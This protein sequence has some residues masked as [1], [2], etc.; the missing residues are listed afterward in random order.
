MSEAWK[1]NLAVPFFT[2]RDNTYIWQQI[3]TEDE[4]DKNGKYIKRK[5]K[6][7]GSK[8]PMAWRTCNITSLCMILHYWGITDKTPNQMIEEVY[9]NTE[10]NWSTSVTGYKVLE[11]WKNLKKIAEYYI[12]L[13]GEESF[14]VNWSEENK[15]SMSL[16]QEQI[17]KGCP[18]MIST[19]LGA[20][21]KSN[22]DKDGNLINE[23]YKQTGH[24]VVV[25]GF[26][27]DGDVIL[28]DPY[29]IPVD[30]NSRIRQTGIAK[31]INGFYYLSEAAAV[32]D[33]IIINRKDFERIYAQNTSLF[34][35]I[36]GPLWQYPCEPMTEPDVE[37]CYPIKTNN[38]WHDGIHL[39]SAEGFRSI[40]SGRLM[41]ARNADVM[42]DNGEVH[43]S[44]SF[45]L[46]RYQLPVS[47][48]PFFYALYMHLKTVDLKSE[49]E[50]FMKNG[51]VS[52]PL[53][54]TWYEQIFNSLLPRYKIF[55]LS[56]PERIS[57]DAKNYNAIYEAEIKDGMFVVKI[58]EESPKKEKVLMDFGD[59]A[60]DAGILS[61][62]M[63]AYLLPVQKFQTVCD[64]ESYSDIAKLKFMVSTS[65]TDFKNSEGYYFFYCG[66]GS[67]RKLC[68]CKNEK[69]NKAETFASSNIYN[70][71]SYSYY[72]KKL[73]SLY[74]GE[75]VN[76]H[77]KMPKEKVEKPSMELSLS[78]SSSIWSEN[79]SCVNCFETLA[80]EI[81]SMKTTIQDSLIRFNLTAQKTGDSISKEFKNKINSYKADRKQ[82]IIYKL[83]QISRSLDSDVAEDTERSK[84]DKEWMIYFFQ[85]AERKLKT[86]VNFEKEG[87]YDVNGDYQAIRDAFKSVTSCLP[88]YS[89]YLIA[90]YEYLLLSLISISPERIKGGGEY[91]FYPDKAITIGWLFDLWGNAF[92][93]IINCYE[94]LVNRR[95]IDT[96]IEIPKGAKIG[97]G[98]V[99]PD[100]VSRNADCIHFEIFSKE[101]ILSS[102]F[103]VVEDTDEDNFYNPS[104][105]TER[106][107]SKLDFTEQK[108]EKYIKYAEDNIL[109]KNEIRNIY[110]HFAVFQN[111]VTRHKTEWAHKEY[112]QKDVE[113]MLRIKRTYYGK[114]VMEAVDYY[115]DY[116]EKYSWYD[117]KLF[118]DIEDDILYFCHPTILIYFLFSELTNK[119]ILKIQ[120]LSSKTA[121]GQY[122]IMSEIVNDSTLSTK[123]RGILA[124]ELR[125]KRNAMKLDELF[126][127]SDSEKYNFM[128]EDLR[129]FLN[130][131]ED[132]TME[133]SLSE[134][135]KG[136]GWKKMFLGGTLF[137]QHNIENGLNIK[138]VNDNDGREVVFKANGNMIMD[139]PDKGT[140]NYC[141]GNFFTTFPGGDHDKYDVQPF[142][143]LKKRGF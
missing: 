80:S 14:C 113:R 92:D 57:E 52:E 34:L 107:L 109:L 24:I 117:K 111:L 32:G 82:L 51:F 21:F 78:A 100:S 66:N 88:A 132:G 50:T 110:A 141:N 11:Y 19:G 48:N 137:H 29:G 104:V 17:A 69:I 25:R 2:Q 90:A 4:K 108:K 143:T 28:N 98:T 38:Y 120:S 139:Y 121:V 128:N 79:I 42:G 72:V 7:F 75:V 37:N 93:Y 31:N 131:K 73:Y 125:K 76:F 55:D 83:K 118:E 105:I 94:L 68:C 85:S 39:Q 20:N 63:K 27:N 116:Y 91:R 140:Y 86:K 122:E 18:V 58:N 53:R 74:K 41:A 40:G 60:N 123:E 54:G 12:S 6:P 112:S 138:Y 36:E 124:A 127:E 77:E 35:Y 8:Y 67:G 65:D 64:I 26:T 126:N 1:R 3:A 45:A 22:K 114:E 43:G 106:I 115:N 129:D 135:K 70:E 81:S 103:P 96:Y 15:L 61:R 5:G 44:G 56:L 30:N 95:Y 101:N 97:D 133:Y 136:N 102:E 142:R 49:L 89:A 99:I 46:V 13:A 9:S 87:K 71:A 84:T 59:G 130:L 16:L 10:W 33:N 23:G 47:E 119:Y 62:H 134:L